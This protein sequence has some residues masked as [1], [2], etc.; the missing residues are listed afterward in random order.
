MRGLRIACLLSALLV[1]CLGTS[2]VAVAAKHSRHGK[3][4]AKHGKH[5]KKVK[6][7]NG[8]TTKPVAQTNASAVVARLRGAG[9]LASG[10]SQD[11]VDYAMSPG[12][13]TQP[14]GRTDMFVGQVVLT[15]PAACDEAQS[16][17]QQP[18]LTDQLLEPIF[19]PPEDAGPSGPPPGVSG[20]ITLD[21]KPASE[22]SEGFAFFDDFFDAKKA[23][24]EKKIDVYFSKDR[25]FEPD[26]ATPHTVKVKVHDTCAGTGQ[27]YTVKDV[28]I[29]VIGFS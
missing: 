7:K 6:K 1:A 3:H 13:W 10:D 28:R 21:D 18:S 15:P 27:N 11:G 25:L 23:G 2:S 17:S 9:P 24:Q 22:D 5:A 8:K 19:G 29:N 12:T 4:H 14:A 26:A 16:E 20:E